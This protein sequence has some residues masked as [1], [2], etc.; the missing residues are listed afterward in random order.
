M[1]V[2]QPNGRAAVPRRKGVPASSGR[3]G[4][5]RAFEWASSREDVA[6]MAAKTHTATTAPQR[7]RK[8]PAF[9]RMAAM[10]PCDPKEIVKSGWRPRG[11]LQRAVELRV[12]AFER[13]EGVVGRT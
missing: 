1:A 9:R 3:S 6:A 13:G 10:M 8:A 7:T 2:D 4:D 11:L 12:D 5:H